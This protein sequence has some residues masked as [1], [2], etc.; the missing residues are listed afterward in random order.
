MRIK[1]KQKSS[2]RVKDFCYRFRHI[3]Q[4]QLIS[5][6]RWIRC[7]NSTYIINLSPF[8]CEQNI[9]SSHNHFFS[10][11]LQFRSIQKIAENRL[12]LCANKL[13]MVVIDPMGNWSTFNGIKFSHFHPIDNYIEQHFIV[14][15]INSY[16]LM[17]KAKKWR[18][19][20]KI[21]MNNLALIMWWKLLVFCVFHA[22]NFQKK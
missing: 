21:A 5:S 4:Q 18:E 1:W 7:A 12:K 8:N 17:A 13:F 16:L 9:N 11:F 19:K 3:N 10:L 15:Q 6:Y 22:V 20:K 14:R 2:Q